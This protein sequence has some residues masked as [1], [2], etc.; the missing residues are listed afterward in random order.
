MVV[1]GRAS[2]MFCC[3]H[4]SPANSDDTTYCVTGLECGGWVCEEEW[5]HPSSL[6][7]LGRQQRREVAYRRA[8]RGAP[9][10]ST[11]TNDY[12]GN[13]AIICARR[14]CSKL[15]NELDYQLSRAHARAGCHLLQLEDHGCIIVLGVILLRADGGVLAPS[16]LERYISQAAVC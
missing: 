10:S 15:P 8:W 5:T 6:H 16:F 7:L 9:V 14:T 12:D 4:R 1:D 3:R 2:V 13:G 11:D